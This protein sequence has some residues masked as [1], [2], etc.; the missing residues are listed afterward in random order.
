MALLK[1]QHH[2]KLN[3]VTAS[4]VQSIANISTDVSILKVSSFFL[5]LS[6][7]NAKHHGVITASWILD[8]GATDHMV[9]SSSIFS[10]NT[11]FVSFSVTL[12]NG[13][14]ASVS[15]VGTIKFIDPIILENVLCVPL[16]SFNLISARKITQ[17][18]NCC[19]ILLSKTCFIH[20][21]S[22]WTMAGM[23]KM[24]QGLYH[25]LQK[26]TCPSALTN[27]L[28]LIFIKLLLLLS[29]VNNSEELDLWHYRL[30]HSSYPTLHLSGS[31]TTNKKLCL[32]YSLA[33]LHKFFF[34]S[35]KR[36]SE[37][38]FELVHCDLWGPC[39]DVSHDGSKYFLTIVDDH[40]RY[41]WVYLLRQKSG[42]SNVI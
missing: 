3:S 25:L 36:R 16:F 34:P 30:G 32:V 13:D 41:T 4:H 6:A 26:K 21:L 20:D 42:A 35:S 39:N 23:D 9:C 11:T 2:Q 1:P 8:T 15:H 10:S 18:L 24:H 38:C 22:T 12:P 5:G 28:A 17:S 7:Y 31:S 27:T 33:N 40:S 14:M 29:I 19:L 37:K